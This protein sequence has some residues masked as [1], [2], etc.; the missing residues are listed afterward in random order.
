MGAP[1]RIITSSHF[2]AWLES[3]SPAV[4]ARVQ[5]ALARLAQLGP[6]L[7]RPLVDTLTG[8]SITN[9]KEL[10]PTK[11]VRVLFVFDARRNAVVLVAGDKATD[12]KFYARAIKKAEEIYGEYLAE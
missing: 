11:S 1:Y 4:K 9:L 6:M 3:L 5:R 2:D 8:S 7:G 10:R 12:K